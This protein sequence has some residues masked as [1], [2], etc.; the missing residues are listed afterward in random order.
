MFYIKW[1]LNI[2]DGLIEFILF[3]KCNSKI[4]LCI[5]EYEL[6]SKIK[7]NKQKNKAFYILMQYFFFFSFR[8]SAQSK[9]VTNNERTNCQ[10]L[11]CRFNWPIENR[12]SL[13]TRHYD[14]RMTKR[15]GIALYHR[16]YRDR[17]YRPRCICSLGSE[18]IR[19]QRDRR[20]TCCEPVRDNGKVNA[21]D[22]SKRAVF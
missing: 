15:F 9:Y 19:F 6:I 2:W 3:E 8:C 11:V 16:L 18:L 13:I 7:Y 10:T 17:R 4:E 14:R 20:T 5:L 22:D 21:M 12:S 1:I